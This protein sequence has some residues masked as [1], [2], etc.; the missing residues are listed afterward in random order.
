MM[1][2]KKSLTY[3]RLCVKL[4]VCSTNKSNQ[5]ALT[6]PSLTTIGKRQGKTK[7]RNAAEAQSA[8]QL[9]QDWA[10]L[11]KR[12]GVDADKK[13]QS[14]AMKA[15]P[16]EYKLEAPVGRETAKL[17]SRDT[18]HTG[19]ISSKA[20]QQYTGD[21]MIGIAQMSKSNAVPVFS[22]TEAIEVA[23]MRRG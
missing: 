10:D 21:K 5:M 13:R 12:W 1:A 11:Q 23:R 7:F 18:G 14:R 9:D 3:N 19:A 4:R 2:L 17:P 8:R 22:K 15:A 20:T 6:H 16:L